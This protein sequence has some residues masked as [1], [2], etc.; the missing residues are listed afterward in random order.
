MKRN[1]VNPQRVAAALTALLAAGT[2]VAAADDVASLYGPQPP[3]NASY[4]RVLNLSS[5]EARVVL[6]GSEARQTLA[7]RT[8][9]RFSVLPQG[10]PAR[11]SVDGEVLADA[12]A[13][14]RA[15]DTVM[16]A[17][18]RDAQGWHTM[19]IVG[20]YERVDGLQATLR[21]FNFVPGCSANISV[22]GDGPTVFAHVAN[23]A[24][25]TRAINPVR[26]KLVGQCGK[27]AS[28]PL[29]LPA[30]AAGDSYSLF[31][32]GDA[33]KP[34]LIGARDALAWPPAAR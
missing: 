20:R 2:A 23:G 32:V 10:T 1:L 28:A 27:N 17:L 3:E 21:V 22:D 4:L 13:P 31:V 6:A 33:A 24:Q 9:T 19:R 16:V 11:V 29:P 25:D 15:G 30:L 5:Q 12:A 34:V 18:R 26:A 7:P 8:A 14:A